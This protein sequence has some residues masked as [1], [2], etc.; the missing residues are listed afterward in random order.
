M[1]D[2]TG[3]KRGSPVI[4]DPIAMEKVI[5]NPKTV[6]VLFHEN[7]QKLLILLIEKEMNIIDLKNA[8]NLN[9][10]TIKRH[11]TDLV[12]QELVKQTRIETNNYGVKM[13]FYRATAKQFIVTMKWP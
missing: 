5:V 3:K 11:L 13:K 1:K 9:P 6:P 2:Q 8:T 10:G 4:D 7:K 12:E